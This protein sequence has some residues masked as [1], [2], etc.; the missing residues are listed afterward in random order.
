MIR[1]VVSAAFLLFALTAH[2]AELPRE[3]VITPEVIKEPPPFVT[4]VVVP[5][6]NCAAASDVASVLVVGH[7]AEDGRHLAVF[8]LGAD[9]RPSGEPS[10]VTLPKPEAL[11]K[12]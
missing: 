6:A 8:R 7:R 12:N 11:A 9:G 3:F 5:G 10:W 4:Q 2:S 1:L